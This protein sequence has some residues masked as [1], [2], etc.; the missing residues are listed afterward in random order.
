MQQY[1]IELVLGLLAGLFLGIT[2]IAPT[3]VI[4]IA[5]DILKIGDYKSNLGAILLLNIFPITISS[6]YQFYKSKQINYSLG[7]ILLF[8]IITGSYFGSKM[9][10]GKNS[11]LTVK[12][13]KYLTAFLSL[14]V[15]TVFLIS[16]YYDTNTN[17]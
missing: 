5:L 14:F 6:V 17:T 7:F 10:V 11:F 8:S 16:A 3:G 12:N 13:I 1:L 4:L 2:G 9:V 15:G